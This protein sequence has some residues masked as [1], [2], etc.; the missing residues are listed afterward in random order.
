MRL[1]LRLSL[2]YKAMVSAAK[3]D[4]EVVG[5]DKQLQRKLKAT[6]D[7]NWALLNSIFKGTTTPDIDAA[8]DR[9]QADVDEY[10]GF[11]KLAKEEKASKEGSEGAAA[12]EKEVDEKEVNEK[13]DTKA[14]KKAKRSNKSTESWWLKNALW[15]V[16]GIVLILLTAGIAL[17]FM[18]MAVKESMDDEIDE[19]VGHN[20]VVS[21]DFNRGSA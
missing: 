20:L 17:F 6:C 19:I 3:M 9:L 13:D 10:S 15:I 2:V 21:T 5:E 16:S 4:A 18:L 11:Q 7:K 14:L 1:W 12:K 8:I